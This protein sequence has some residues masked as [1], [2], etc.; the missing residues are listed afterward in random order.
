MAENLDTIFA[1]LL[2]LAVEAGLP[3]VEESTSYG[4]KALKVD[5]KS[6]VAVKGNETIVISIALDEKEALL[7]M[8][9]EIYFQTPHYVGWQ[10][11]P[12]RI[13][14]IGDTELTD[15]LIGAWFLRAPKKL[16]LTYQR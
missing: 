15:R 12:V 2:R 4:N 11:L 6:F 10:Y 1:R 3:G 5:G 14:V 13:D 7:E 9:P 16:A 8:A